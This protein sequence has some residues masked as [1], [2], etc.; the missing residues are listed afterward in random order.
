VPF[1]ANED[2]IALKI[3]SGREKDLEDV[4]MLRRGRAPHIDWK[5]ARARL[6]ELGEAIDDSAMVDTFDRI[7]G[8]KKKR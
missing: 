4:R 6:A 2:L 1:V 5:I 8:K 3:L 7:V